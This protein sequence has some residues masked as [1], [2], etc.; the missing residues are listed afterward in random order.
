MVASWIGLITGIVGIVLACVAIVY[1]YVTNRRADQVNDATIRALAH[2]ESDIDKLSSDVRSLIQDA[3]AK[4]VTTPGG[5]EAGAAGNGTEADGESEPDGGTALDPALTEELKAEIAEAVGQK[6]SADLQQRLDQTVDDFQRRTQERAD[7]FGRGGRL[8]RREPR[9]DSA[10][11]FAVTLE[12]VRALS[13]QAQ[14]LLRALAGN[15]PLTRSEYRALAQGDLGAA[16]HELR[17]RG[18]MGPVTPAGGHAPDGAPMYG[19][20]PGRVDAIQAAARV[21]VPNPTVGAEV[22]R[23]LKAAGYLDPDPS[24]ARDSGPATSG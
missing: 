15:R 22:A 12:A 17:A 3:W 9:R 7:L 23:L 19:L 4:F 2:I 1:A 10:Q 8:S 24:A 18:L 5:L 13:T 21:A 6:V 14:E 20:P 16:F 11:S